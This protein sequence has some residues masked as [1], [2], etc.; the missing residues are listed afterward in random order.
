MNKKNIIMIIAIIVVAIAIGI[1]IFRKN[2]DNKTTSNSN[3]TVVTQKNSSNNT[4]SKATNLEADESGNIVIDTTNIGSKA[5][6]Y[7]YDAEGTTIRLFA[8]KASDGTIRMAFN[9]CQVCNPSPK[10]YFVQSG[11]NFICQNCGNSFSTDNIGKERGGCNPIPITTDERI[12][13]DNTITLTKQ[14]IEGYKD[15]F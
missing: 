13:G 1:I 7:T 6:F 14:F 9:T 3:N 10:A 8:V 11:K 4:E 15:N 2:S 12:D 5:S